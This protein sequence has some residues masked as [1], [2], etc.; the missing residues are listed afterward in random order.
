[1]KNGVLQVSGAAGLGWVKDVRAKALLVPGVRAVEF[2]PELE[3]DRLAFAQSKTDIE[4][5]VVKFP[6]ATAALSSGERQAL[7][8]M[9]EE[10]KTLLAAAQSLHQ[11]VNFTVVGHTD[12][13]GAETSNLN[14]S[15]RRADRVA[16]ELI[17]NGVPD[18]LLQATGVGTTQPIRSEDSDANREFNRSTSILVKIQNP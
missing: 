3:P 11:T 15:Q 10:M 14:L 12:S 6:V 13:T 17:Q 7:R 8:K 2:A 18:K 16:Y 5:T 4:K 9:A 1:V